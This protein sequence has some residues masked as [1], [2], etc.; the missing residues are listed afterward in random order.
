MSRQFSTLAGLCLSSGV[1]LSTHGSATAS[2]LQRRPA[3]SHLARFSTFPPLVAGAAAASAGAS[4]AAFSASTRCFH[5]DTSAV[6]GALSA[7]QG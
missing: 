1:I 2:G 7:I 5:F 3:S 4:A 6:A